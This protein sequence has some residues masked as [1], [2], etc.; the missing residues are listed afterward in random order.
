[1]R[2]YTAN[3]RRGRAISGDVHHQARDVGILA[4]RAA[5]KSQRHAARREGRSLIDTMLRAEAAADGR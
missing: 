1:M 3:T 4:A 5:A 2:L